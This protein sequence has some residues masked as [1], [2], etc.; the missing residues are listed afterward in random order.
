M[1]ML[2]EPISECS[3]NQYQGLALSLLLSC[4]RM[5]DGNEEQSLCTLIAAR[6]FRRS[7]GLDF[8]PCAARYSVSHYAA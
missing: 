3:C 6:L 5:L 7:L 2:S 4:I 8:V 1:I